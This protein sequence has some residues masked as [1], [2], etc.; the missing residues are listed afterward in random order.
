AGVVRGGGYLLGLPVELSQREKIN[1]MKSG[2]GFR[3]VEEVDNQHKEYLQ[4]VDLFL[5]FNSYL[6]LINESDEYVDYFIYWND[7]F[8]KKEKNTIYLEIEE[9]KWKRND[10]F[11][12]I[13]GSY[14][15]IPAGTFDIQKEVEGQQEKVLSGFMP[16]DMNVNEV[17]FNQWDAC[18]SAGGCTYIPD[19][20]GWGRGENPVINVSY[21]DVTEQFIPW[22]TSVTS[23]KYR[24]PTIHEWEYAKEGLTF[25]VALNEGV[26]N[27]SGN[28]FDCSNSLNKPNQV[29]QYL[30]NGFGLFDML[31]NVS[32]W[33]STCINENSEICI[34]MLVAG[35]SWKDNGLNSNQS[36]DVR[37]DSIGFRLAL[38]PT[39]EFSLKSENEKMLLENWKNEELMKKSKKINVSKVEEDET[40]D[41]SF[42]DIK[43]DREVNDLVEDLID[44]L[45][46]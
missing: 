30:E 23:N 16:F 5:D 31:G 21:K 39:H 18:V 17:T 20:N 36:Q 19:D 24:L 14:V 12:E 38:V 41:S 22:L 11:K 15:K 8:I 37:S 28:C 32:E 29:M 7:F 10:F 13:S 26:E 9:S 33:T 46:I 45:E 27:L 4:N 6:N 43:S 40:M 42:K 25:E 44:F 34:K 35:E 3:L 2:A 1:F